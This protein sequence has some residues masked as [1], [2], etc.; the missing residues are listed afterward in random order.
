MAY[1]Q[2]KQAG[3]GPMQKTGSGVP[4]ALLQNDEKSGEHPGYKK[5]EYKKP[6]EGK[7]LTTEQS[8]SNYDSKQYFDKQA[9]LDSIREVRMKGN[10]PQVG[11]RIDTNNSRNSPG[12]YFDVKSI[13]SETGDYTVQGKNAHFTD[14]KVISRKDVKRQKLRQMSWKKS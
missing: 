9:P 11:G 5:P 6:Y 1:D 8:F 12:T 10:W 4:S 13:N 3:R 2:K 14:R 7:N